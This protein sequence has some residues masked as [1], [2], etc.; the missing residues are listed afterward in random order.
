MANKVV[1]QSWVLFLLLALA[2]P[3]FGQLERSVIE[4][5]VTDPHGAFT[6]GV[7]VTVMATETNVTLP[8]A[9]NNAGYYRV[10]SLVPG[11]YQVH[12]EASGFSRLDLKGIVVPAGQTIRADAQLQLGTIQQVVEVSASASQIQTAAT[13]F[14]TTV[15]AAAIQQIPLSGRD[16][17]QLVFL[18][19]GI[20]GNGPPG[21][22]FGFN[23][24]FGAFPDPTHLQGSGVSVNGGQIGSNAWY[25]DGNFNLASANADSVVVNPSPH[26]VTDFQVITNG[27]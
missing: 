8:T 26:A 27:L 1:T 19:P 21:S 13:N 5:T 22:S 12:F 10:T 25:L 7:K 14:S 16:L 24:Q 23:S 15:E 20:I 4:G 9:T 3:C 18:V 2:S 17:Q 6:S 11:K